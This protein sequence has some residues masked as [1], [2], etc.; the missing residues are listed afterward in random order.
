M[1]LRA[2]DAKAF[3][4]VRDNGTPEKLTIVF[5]VVLPCNHNLLHHI[6]RD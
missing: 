1:T 3:S 2:K 4:E 5:F 6:S